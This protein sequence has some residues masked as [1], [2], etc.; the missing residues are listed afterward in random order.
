LAGFERDQVSKFADKGRHVSH[1]SPDMVKA[2][3]YHI[4]ASEG[5]RTPSRASYQP[6]YGVQYGGYAPSDI[7]YRSGDPVPDLRPAS[8]PAPESARGYGSRQSPSITSFEDFQRRRGGNRTPM[9]ARGSSDRYYDGDR[10]SYRG[11]DR[12]SIAS[13]YY[14]SDMDSQG[15]RPRRSK[16]L[17]RASRRSDMSERSRYS[18]TPASG[19]FSDPSRTVTSEALNEALRGSRAV[20]QKTPRKS[21]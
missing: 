16:S 10:G 18:G 21:R 5:S 2:M 7:S 12:S 1:E 19:L 17:D 9:S 15:G 3:Y 11:G 20:G 4:N 13:S 14:Y 8:A 6:S